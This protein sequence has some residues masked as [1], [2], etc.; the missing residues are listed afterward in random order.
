MT[1]AALVL[2]AGEGTRMK[3]RT[4]K[5][6]HR[7]CGKPM[8]SW[9]LDAVHALL[10]EGMVR[11]ILVVVGNGG[12]EVKAELEGRAEFVFQRERRGTGHA[13]MVAAPLIR[14]D[15]LLVITASSSSSRMKIGRAH[16]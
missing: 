7:V 5:V 10:A 11:R 3:S 6:L 16:V 9:V 12:D 1:R 4:P 2:A 15:E 8:I 13:V 14:E